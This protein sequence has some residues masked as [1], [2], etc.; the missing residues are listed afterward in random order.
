VSL[1][2]FLAESATPVQ[3]LVMADCKYQHTAEELR[4]VASILD[5]LNAGDANQ[6]IAAAGGF[7]DIYWCDSM[8]GRIDRDD[9]TW[10]YMPEAKMPRQRTGD[11]VWQSLEP[12]ATVMVQ[13]IL[14]VGYEVWIHSDTFTDPH[15]AIEHAKRISNGSPLESILQWCYKSK[16]VPPEIHDAA[17]KLLNTASLAHDAE[18][19]P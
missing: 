5:V 1:Q 8:M 10:V 18:C 7:L 3:V 16:H 17:A 11:I 9:E 13:T 14:G 19:S 4:H 2:F 15:E 6:T 12:A